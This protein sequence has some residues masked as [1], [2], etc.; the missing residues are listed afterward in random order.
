MDSDKKFFSVNQIFYSWIFGTMC[1]STLMI[2][3]N[4]IKLKNKKFEIIGSAFSCAMSF[5][6]Q[7]HDISRYNNVF[8]LMFFNYLF[9]LF[10]T[11]LFYIISRKLYIKDFYPKIVYSNSFVIKINILFVFILYFIIH[12][13]YYKFK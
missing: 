9:A 10:T 6:I 4:C 13:V 5:L 8:M 3:I 11:P 1:F 7:F 12:I 2:L